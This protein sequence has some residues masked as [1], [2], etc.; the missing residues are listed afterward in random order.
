MLF[1]VFQSYNANY[2]FAVDQVTISKVKKV[3]GGN[4]FT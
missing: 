3:T 4:Y 2:I 1:S